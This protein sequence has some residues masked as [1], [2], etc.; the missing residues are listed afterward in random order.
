MNPTILDSHIHLWRRADGDDVWVASKIGGLARDFSVD[1]W[2]AHAD[3]SG[4]AGAILVQ[5]AHS[6]AETERAIAL[7]AANPRIV[8]VVGWADLHGESL[9]ADVARLATI[10]NWSASGRCRRAPS[11]PTGWPIRV[12]NAGWQRS[13]LPALPSMCW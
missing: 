1:D 7:A 5:A 4:V 3:A 11:A 10:R 9:A 12:L 6:I 2:R 8:G 13:A